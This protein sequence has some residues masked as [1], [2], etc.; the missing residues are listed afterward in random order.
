MAYGLMLIM[1]FASILGATVTYN[2]MRMLTRFQQRVRFIETRRQLE[3]FKGIAS[4]A[5][6]GS[7]FQLFL[8]FSPLAVYIFGL[9]TDVFELIHV[10]IVVLPSG[11]YLLLYV[12]YKK[13]EEEVRTVRI[14]NNEILSEC[15]HVADTWKKRSFPEW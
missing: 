12:R 6:Y 10:L 3:E 11:L 7:L 2:L 5:M 14:D 8:L 13:L 9:A 15:I 1:V 4:A